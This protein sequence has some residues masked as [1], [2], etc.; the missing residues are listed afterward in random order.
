MDMSWDQ[1]VTATNPKIQGTSNLHDA[2]LCEQAGPLDIFILFSSAGAMTGQ[3]GQAK[4]N[5]GNTFLDAFMSYRHSLGLPANVVNIGSI[6]NVGY[7]SEV[8]DTLRA[9]P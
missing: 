6:G 9:T 1:W 2:L 3:W 8:L 7:V 4:Y 5:T